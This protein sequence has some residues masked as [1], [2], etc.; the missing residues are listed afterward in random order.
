[1]CREIETHTER[2]RDQEHNL[3]LKTFVTGWIKL[4]EE[5]WFL[6]SV[7]LDYLVPFPLIFT[8]QVYGKW[9]TTHQIEKGSYHRKG[10]VFYCHHKELCQLWK[11]CQNWDSDSGLHKSHFVGLVAMLHILIVYDEIHKKRHLDWLDGERTSKA[12]LIISEWRG[13]APPRYDVCFSKSVA[14]ITVNGPLS[15]VEIN[16]NSSDVLSKQTQKACKFLF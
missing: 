5:Y 12:S 14:W 6:E 2:E 1:M 4:Y 3:A 7:Y 10:L 13:L 15:V 9:S 11:G 16:T 8:Q